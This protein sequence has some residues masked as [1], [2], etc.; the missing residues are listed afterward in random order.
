MF[1]FHEF[2]ERCGYDPA[3]TRLLRHD[4]RGSAAWLRGRD[5]FLCFACF[6]KRERSP[7]AG[8]PTHACHF[9]AGPLLGERKTGLFI[10]TTEIIRGRPWDRQEMPHVVDEA[11]VADERQS[12]H[13]L[14]LFDLE[15]CAPGQDYAERILTDWGTNPRGWSQWAGN[16]PKPIVELRLEARE[17]PFPGFGAFR[18][19]ISALPSMPRSWHEALEAVRGVYLLVTRDGRQYV[20]SAYG[21]DGFMGRWR[22][23]VANGHGDNRLLRALPAAQRDYSVSI[24]E[25]ASPEM[26]PADIIDRE[27][28]WKEKLGARAHGLNAN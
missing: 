5:A 3:R 16:V 25:V 4:P 6:Q 24:L 20:G 17:D 15:W 13:D 23:Y 19:S 1:Q 12:P 27:T 7:Y 22:A 18:I 2:L 26:S 21:A 11:V 28:A 10:G 9:I 8:N 14:D